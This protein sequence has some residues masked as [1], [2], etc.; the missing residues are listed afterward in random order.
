[1]GVSYFDRCM[2]PGTTNDPSLLKTCD[3]AVVRHG[4]SLS[5]SSMLVAYGKPAD[6]G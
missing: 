5:F 3:K 1:M 6:F 2:Q 4:V